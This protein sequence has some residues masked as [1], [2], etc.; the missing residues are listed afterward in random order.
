MHQS[1]LYIVETL[2]VWEYLKVLLKKN[3]KSTYWNNF[4]TYESILKFWIFNMNL[5]RD[6]IVSNVLYISEQ[7]QN[8]FHSFFIFPIIS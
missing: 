6:H 7:Q 8:K 1:H 5:N 2:R 3:N 4:K